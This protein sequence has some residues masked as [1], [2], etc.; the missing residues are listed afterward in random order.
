MDANPKYLE[1]QTELYEAR[2]QYAIAQANV[3]QRVKKIQAL[4]IELKSIYFDPLS[5][6]ETT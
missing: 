6:F 5:I 1:L 4:M 3:N 2:K